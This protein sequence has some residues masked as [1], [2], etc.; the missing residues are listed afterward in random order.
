MQDL[1]QKYLRAFKKLR[2]DR[3]HGVA[4]HKPILLL[5]VLQTFQTG[6]NK[7]QYID[8]SPEL[9]GLFKSNWSLLV[10][11]KHDCRISYPFYHLK[12]E[13]FWNLIPKEGFVNIDSMGSMVKSL[14]NL[15]RAIESA[16]IENDLFLLMTDETSN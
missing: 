1:L 10:T 12:S 5:S 14:A 6:L 8:I 3:S 16:K 11:S 4:P 9:V 7:T 15:N 13:K 2:I